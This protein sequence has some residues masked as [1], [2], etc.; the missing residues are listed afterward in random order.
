M[1]QE[2]H[3]FFQTPSKCAKNHVVIIIKIYINDRQLT[4]PRGPYSVLLKADNW[5]PSDLQKVIK[6]TYSLN[7]NTNISIYSFVW[8]FE[9]FIHPLAV[10]LRMTFWGGKGLFC[11]FALIAPLLLGMTV[12]FVYCCIS[13]AYKKSVRYVVG[14]Q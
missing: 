5:K 14:A 2:Y 8:T 11:L 9:R 12:T 4:T 1:A 13:R 10:N 6:V 7:P 3:C